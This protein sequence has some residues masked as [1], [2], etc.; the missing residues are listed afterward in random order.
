MR[1]GRV[2][3][4]LDLADMK[5]R[6]FIGSSSEGLEI[7]ENLNV[8]LSRDCETVPW[9]GDIFGLSETYIESLENALRDVEFAV[10]VVTP[11]D[12][13]EM[14]GEQGRV[15]RDNVVFELGLFIGRLGRERSFVVCDPNAVQLPSDLLGIEPARI[16]MGWVSRE[17]RNAVL[18]AAREILDAIRGV[19]RLVKARS[20]DL[21]DRVLADVDALYAASVSWPAID[22]HE[23]TIQT[24][25]TTWAW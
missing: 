10:L 9:N 24:S 4:V 25:D 15:P 8:R 14:R 20:E 5:P 11:D 22:G 7:A 23:I 6:V 17:P 2:K 3:V 12:L 19:P 21:L 16:D 18:P 13:R 1:S